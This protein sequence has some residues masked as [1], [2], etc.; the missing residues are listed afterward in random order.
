M[1]FEL[2]TCRTFASSKI[3]RFENMVFVWNSV[4]WC[5]EI[6][7]SETWHS[8]K[9]VALHFFQLFFLCP[10]PCQPGWPASP[11][12]CNGLWLHSCMAV[13]SKST[14]VFFC[15]GSISRPEYFK[16]YISPFLIFILK[17]WPKVFHKIATRTRIMP[18]R[19]SSSRRRSH[20]GINVKIEIL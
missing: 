12:T 15:F 19:M 17:F 1:K 4:K 13:F 5:S 3:C 6:W 9:N 18:E 8:E 11:C 16:V 14:I 7:C 20:S 2:V 10:P